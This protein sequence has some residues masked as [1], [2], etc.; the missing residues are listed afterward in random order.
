MLIFNLHNFI[1]FRAKQKAVLNVIGL[2]L[3]LPFYFIYIL[4]FN[5]SQKLYR[6]EDEVNSSSEEETS[7]VD[8]PIPS[9]SRG[10]QHMEQNGESSGKQTY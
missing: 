7:A 4:F 1:V 5:M 3:K 2:M 10:I 8:P 9:T 6:V